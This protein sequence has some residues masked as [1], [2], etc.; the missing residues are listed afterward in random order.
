M[1]LDLDQRDLKTLSDIEM[2]TSLYADLVVDMIKK[3]K[4]ESFAL[5]LGSIHNALRKAAADAK[6]VLDR[7]EFLRKSED[8]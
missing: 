3:Q 4:I 1:K 7:V 8:D 2:T 6:N 5:V